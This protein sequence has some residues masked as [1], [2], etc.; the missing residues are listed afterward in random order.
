MMHTYNDTRTR[1]NTLALYGARH[2][3][4]AYRITRA[5]VRTLIVALPLIVGVIYN[6][7]PA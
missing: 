1:D 4:R 6:L 5:I 2:R 7:I 3:S